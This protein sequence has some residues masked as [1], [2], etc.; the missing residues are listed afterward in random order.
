MGESDEFLPVHYDVDATFRFLGNVVDANYIAALD[1]KT[2]I[3][4]DPSQLE[5]KRL[6]SKYDLSESYTLR[7][8]TNSYR[9]DSSYFESIRP[10]PLTEHEQDLYKDFFLSRDTS[11]RYK[12]P[13]NKNLEFWGR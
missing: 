8:D 7:S 10:I 2:I 12:K 5:R 11:Y 3:Q 9:K 4:K 1:Y 13:K 6:K